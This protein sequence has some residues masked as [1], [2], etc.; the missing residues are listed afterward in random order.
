MR[1]FTRD[2]L[3]AYDGREGRPAYIA[4]MGKVY[5]VSG[6]MLW[7][8]GFH[9]GLHQAGQDLSPFLKQAP[10]GAG[11]LSKFHLVGDLID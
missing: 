9:Q 1:S 10:H 6:S 2:E 8:N 4:F 3:K 7:Q 11:L 5:D